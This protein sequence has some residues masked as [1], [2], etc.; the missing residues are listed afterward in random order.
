MFR[1]SVTDWQQLLELLS[2]VLTLLRVLGV[3]N[4]LLISAT[5]SRSSSV[6]LFLSRA[7]E[8]AESP[9]ISASCEPRIV[10]VLRW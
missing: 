2:L 5:G 1:L 9:V 4:S 10:T 8:V 6:M 7:V 3:A